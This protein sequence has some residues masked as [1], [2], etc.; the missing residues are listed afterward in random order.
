[1]TV[2][3]FIQRIEDDYLEKAL[4]ELIAKEVIMVYLSAKEF[5]R[6][7]LTRSN[8]IPED[9]EDEKSI[10]ITIKNAD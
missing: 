1:M 6:A 10:E 3:E 9:E 8:Y 2:D 4:D 5:Q 7:K